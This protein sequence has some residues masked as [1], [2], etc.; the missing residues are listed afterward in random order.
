MGWQWELLIADYGNRRIR[1]VDIGG[2]IA[3][4]A[5]GGSSYPGEYEAATNVNV[6]SIY[7]VAADSMGKLVLYRLRQLSNTGGSQLWI[8]HIHAQKFR[9]EHGRLLFGRH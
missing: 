2:S 5:G 8:A 6:S 4:V 1:R 3:T 9:D 7:D